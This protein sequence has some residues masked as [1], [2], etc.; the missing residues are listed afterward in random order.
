MHMGGVFLSPTRN[1]ANN[2]RAVTYVSPWKLEAHPHTYAEYED[3]FRSKMKACGL[4]LDKEP[5]PE[6]D[7]KE[8]G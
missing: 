3:E 2:N 5:E 6:S 8:E 4:P 7:G 1:M